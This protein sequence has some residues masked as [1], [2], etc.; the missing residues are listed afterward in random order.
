MSSVAGLA[1]ADG[2]AIDKVY[3]PYVQPLERELE[4]RMISADGEQKQ[5]LGLGKSFSDQLFIEGYLVFE[6]ENDNDLNLSEYEIEAKWQLTEQGELDIDWGII[7]ELEK[8]RHKDAWELSTALLMEKEWGRWVGAVNLRGIYERGDNTK[9]EL[10]SE[11]AMQVRYRYSR[12]LEPALELYSG[13]NT[14]AL[15]PVFMGEIR[16]G[17][18]KKLHWETGVIF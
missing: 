14:K 3:H 10:E 13:Q 9:T 5:R 8:S 18:G 1:K 12:Q 2:L 17:A 7:A 15:G 6:E 16:F 11:L 4:W